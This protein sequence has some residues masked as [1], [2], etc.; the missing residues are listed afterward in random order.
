[1]QK[2]A[3]DLIGSA[4][5]FFDSVKDGATKITS[6]VSLSVLVLAGI[7]LKDAET[8]AEKLFE[9]L[10]IILELK[11]RSQDLIG[12]VKD[13]RQAMADMTFDNISHSYEEEEIRKRRK[14]QKDIESAGNSANQPKT[15]K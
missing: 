7:V 3:D 13:D 14:L 9:T 5:G 6:V 11:E 2:A 4:K 10:G 15:S 1:M 12:S 8:P